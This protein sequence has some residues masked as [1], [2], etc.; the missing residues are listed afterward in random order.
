MHLKELQNTHKQFVDALR[1][2]SIDLLQPLFDV[3][4]CVLQMQVHIDV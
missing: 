1:R 2:V 4:E 3:I